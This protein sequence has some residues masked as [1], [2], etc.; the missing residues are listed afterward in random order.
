MARLESIDQAIPVSMGTTDGGYKAGVC[1]P[2]LGPPPWAN[3]PWVF[4]Y[5]GFAPLGASA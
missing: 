2:R 3:M 1:P 5:R 4:C